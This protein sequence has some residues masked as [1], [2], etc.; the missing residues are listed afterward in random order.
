M[1]PVDWAFLGQILDALDESTSSEAASNG[2]LI[3]SQYK[4]ASGTDKGRLWG[5]SARE[6]V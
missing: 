4:M 1:V 5:P 6:T 2:S 3:E